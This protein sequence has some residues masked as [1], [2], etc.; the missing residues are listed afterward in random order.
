MRNYDPSNTQKNILWTTDAKVELPIYMR[1]SG[2]GSEKPRTLFELWD[3]NIEKF[4]KLNAL[5]VKN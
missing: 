3:Q 2:V 5:A 4:G 1:K